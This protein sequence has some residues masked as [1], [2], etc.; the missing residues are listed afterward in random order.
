MPATASGGIAASSRASAF[1]AA[2]SCA[3]GCTLWT[4]PI[5]SAS[6]AIDLSRPQHQVQRVVAPDA[7]G[8]ARRSAPRRHH[9]KFH[10]G[11]AN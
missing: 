5:F 11:Q 2:L 8:Q 10:L 7:P 3:N 4:K 1:A 6:M 9:P